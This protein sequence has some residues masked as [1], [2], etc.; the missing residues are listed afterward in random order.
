[1]SAPEATTRRKS[2]TRREYS[3]ADKAIVLAAL[4]ANDGNVSKTAKQFSL[5]NSTVK[6]WADGKNQHP[7]VAELCEDKKAEIVEL[8]DEAVREMIHASKGKP[9]ETAL[10]PLWTSI[11]IGLDKKQLLAGQPTSITESRG[12]KAERVEKVAGKLLQLVRKTG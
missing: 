3:D 9:A 6:M 8:I 12:E 10:Q 7:I 5:P 2:R 11:G 1:M 4:A